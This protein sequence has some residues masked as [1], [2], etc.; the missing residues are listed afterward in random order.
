MSA[1]VTG[2]LGLVQSRR[3][4]VTLRAAAGVLHIKQVWTSRMRRARRARWSDRVTATD[5]AS[6]WP[7]APKQGSI[8]AA[9]GA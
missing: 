9:K 7:I 6:P 4:T 8:A 2:P 3:L 5:D 1:I